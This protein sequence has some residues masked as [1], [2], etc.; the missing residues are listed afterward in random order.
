VLRTDPLNP[1]AGAALLV[2]TAVM[3]VSEILPAALRGPLVVGYL[4]LA[5]GYAVLPFFGKE[6]W[7]L[8]AL[9]VLS[10]GAALATLVATT[11]SEI[12]WWHVGVGVAATE[13]LVV[14]AVLVRSWRNRTAVV[15]LVGGVR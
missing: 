1:V 5:P 15:R 13:L 12:G 8:H 14:T 9:L 3:A 4:L 11:M 7:L 2:A 10:S 6:H